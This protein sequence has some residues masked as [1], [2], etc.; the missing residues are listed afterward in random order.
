MKK[1][2]IIILLVVSFIYLKA[3]SA[4]EAI[5]KALLLEKTDISQ[6]YKI[7]KDAKKDF[8]QDP[9]V[10]SVFGYMAG[11][12]AKETY[13]LR[14][15]LL[16]N[17]AL[18]AFDEALSIQ[19]D[20]KNARLW[21]GILKI[22]MPSFLGKVPEGMADLE[23]VEERDDLSQMEIMQIKFFL[24]MGYEKTENF[25][26]AIELFEEVIEMNLDETYVKDSK[27]RIARQN[28]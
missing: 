6:A 20:H 15:L 9:D 16:V 1:I 28:K 4:Q 11:F 8:P 18:S 25:S 19:E 5:D 24:G 21:G 17:S 23:I 22:N 13:K 3:N 10:L 14:A 7:M 12:E 2:C 27:M 26:K